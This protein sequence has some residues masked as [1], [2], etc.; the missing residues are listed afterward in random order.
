MMRPTPRRLLTL[1]AVAGMA[2]VG[3]SGCSDSGPAADERAVCDAM[4][5]MLDDLASGNK[6]G[7]LVQMY[8]LYGITQ[9]SSNEQLRASG[10]AFFDV[11]GAEVE[12][13]EQMTIEETTAYANDALD[14][15]AAELGAIADECNRIGAP[16]EI[17][18]T[19]S[20]PST[21]S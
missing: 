21:G 6:Q 9:E 15:S 5:N 19:S 12:G 18:S 20:T 4:Q 1:T 10:Q 17:R 11:I 16:I 13:H 2:L 7:G 8:S 14:R 3:L